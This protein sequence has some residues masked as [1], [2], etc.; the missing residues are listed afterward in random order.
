[1][2][3][4]FKLLLG[5][6]LSGFLCVAHAQ[7]YTISGY[8]SD[9][10][11]SEKLIGANIYIKNLK[12]GTATNL[13]GFYSLTLPKGTYSIRF[14][15]V[16][17]NV[18]E[19][20]IDLDN[21]LTLNLDLEPIGEIEEVIVYGEQQQHQKTTMGVNKLSM[22][23]LDL[24][25]VFLG[26]KDII[27]TIQLL[28]GVQSGTEGSSGMY[29]RGGGPDQ[30]LILLDGVPVYNS[31]HL[32][33][34]FSVF[35][36]DAINNVTL[37]KG[38]FPARYGG[39]LSS[40][41]D[42]RMKEG[43]MKEYEGNFSIGLISSKFNIE[44]PIWKDKTSFVLSARRT[45]IDVLMMPLVRS[46]TDGT[47]A[48]YYFYDVNA[49]INHK[50]SDRNRLYLS[51]YKGLDKFYAENNNKFDSNDKELEEKFNSNLNWGNLISALRWNYIISPKLFLNTTVTYSKY[52]LGILA[53]N[54][55]E[56]FN[57]ENKVYI[58]SNSSEFLSNIEDVAAKFD[59]D[60]IPTPNHYIKFG[61]GNT[62]HTFRPGAQQFKSNVSK[63]L[64]LGSK[65]VP[66][67]EFYA[68]IE[69]DYK[70]TDKLKANFGLHFAGLNVKSKNY[71]SFQPRVSGRYLLNEVSSVKASYSRM[72]QFLHLLS[73][74]TI[75]LP[76]DLW[77]PTTEKVKPEYS[78][79][80][81]IGYSS[82]IFEKYDLSI[83]SY[84]KTTNNLI[85][86]SD[87]ASFFGTDKDWENKILSGTGE[88]YG[89]E[90]LLE[91]KFGNTTGWI[92]YTLSWA[93]RTFDNINF[94]KEF[95][96][97]FDRRHDISVVLS[98]K[99][100]DGFDMGVT[101]VYG[102]GNAF[103]LGTQSYT[104]MKPDNQTQVAEYVPYRN[105][106]RMPSYHRMDIGFNWHKKTKSYK[107][108]WSLSIY[109]LYNRKNPFFL[110]FATKSG[111][112]KTLKQVSLFPILPSITYSLKF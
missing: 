21:D 40:V 105:N 27:K 79:Q 100:S 39:R 48:G 46:Q 54:E 77:V 95:P 41:L 63:D 44:G 83:E 82:K 111:N 64:N 12:S 97:K 42:I 107:R 80:F 96:Y 10:N 71:F 70:I 2:N 56:N 72:N 5:F 47:D 4:F 17:Y 76:T 103:T 81:S 60:F 14:S 104:T 8:L 62:F 11:S 91:K 20:S 30:N 108:T 50:F 59:I 67:N 45:Y 58:E 78:D 68:Y 15:Y 7:S 98:H 69:D 16:G 36:S 49:K 90:F 25:P 33:G 112:Q 57:D 61:F 9:K 75:G 53:E 3:S 22:K 31:S 89:A 106:Y 37:T 6:V 34:F 73:N 88:A 65:S 87:G 84:Y 13:Y 74:P 29:V 85:E 32:F 18:I 94:G 99:F 110:Y 101:W 51:V 92:G 52:E 35:N 43:N 86:Y 26:E 109:N 102:T 38:A 28:P 66:A 19:Q 24:V 93:N 1:M 55:T 23:T